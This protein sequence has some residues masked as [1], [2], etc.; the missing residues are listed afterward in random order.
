[1]STSSGSGSAQDHAGQARTSMASAASNPGTQPGPGLPNTQFN[2][3]SQDDLYNMFQD[4]ADPGSVQS[5][6][7]V[8]KTLSDDLTDTA[9]DLVKAISTAQA[10]WT[11][12]AADSSLSALSNLVAWHG[13]LAGGATTA[14]KQVEAQSEALT[15]ARK[16]PKPVAGVDPASVAVDLVKNG[17]NPVAT[18]QDAKAQ[19]TAS[20]NA[21]N[22]QVQAAQQYENTLRGTST[23]P[24]FS[25][26]PPS[27][28][29]A[30]APNPTPVS[31]GGGVS[32]GSGYGGGY[33]SGSGSA[34]G[35]YVPQAGG[36]YAPSV[37]TPGPSPVSG[38]TTST[39]GAGGLS[40]TG[41][42]GGYTGGPVAYSGQSPQSG[43]DAAAAGMMPAGPMGGGGGF[44]GEDTYSPGRGYG[45]STG[46]SYGGSAGNGSGT[47]A[48]ARSGASIGGEAARQAAMKAGAAEAKAGGAGTPGGGMGGARG[49]GEDDEEHESPSYLVNDD[50]MSDW[51]GPLPPTAPPV[52]G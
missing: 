16:L 26:A 21:K 6:A 4:D 36:G 9:D 43:Q 34:G 12:A 23:M 18:Y 2:G 48:G 25:T 27:S 3:Y 51:I 52:I 1:M 22:A 13:Q 33:G 14:Q 42:D 7:D 39:S 15:Q 10:G 29:P 35:G 31:G 45:G 28:S 30:P 38:G 37:A 49:R 8:Y 17:L 5:Q 40:T 50:N 20:N 44:G 19:D 32:G 46:G 24:T 11:G 41:Y 47:G